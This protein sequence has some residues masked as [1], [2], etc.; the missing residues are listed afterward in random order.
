MYLLVSRNHGETFQG[1][2]ISKWNVGYCV[3]S[4]EAFAGSGSVVVAGWETEKQVY[5]GR[6][7]AS[8]GKIAQPVAAPGATDNRKHPAVAAN[9]R[10]ETLLA[11]TQ[12]MGWKKGGSLAW[13]IYDNSGKPQREKG[14]A[15]GVP[16]WSLIAAFARPD[17]GFT[18]VY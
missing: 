16:V 17:G 15:A 3:M 1:E 7:D 18:I 6:I 13:Q 4:S 12:G 8:T 5:F 2:D 14:A 9:P 10:G 11:W